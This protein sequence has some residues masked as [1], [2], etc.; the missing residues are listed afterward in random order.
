MLLLFLIPGLLPAQELKKL[1]LQQ[2]YEL[3]QK[4]Y[5]AIRQKDLIRQTSAIN[6][7]NLQKGF[8]P[9]VTISGQAT[10][11]SDVTKIDVSLPGFSFDPPG[12][13]QY[14]LVADV[15]QLIYDGGVTKEQKVVQRLTASV[16]DQ[17]VEVELY[18]LKERINQ[19]Y[20]SIL[21]LDEQLKQV[22]LVKA[23]I[24]IGIKRVDAQVQNGV[25]FKSNLNMLKA[26]L[27]KTEQRAI[28]VKTSKK[29][30]IDALAI[31]IG[32]PLNENIELEKPAMVTTVNEEITRPELKLYSDQAKLIDQQNKLISAKNLPK[33][34]LFVQ[35]GYGKPGLN[36]LKNG[37]DPYYIGGVRFNW[38]LGGLYTKKKEKELT[39]VNKK[40]VDIQKETFV[41][42]TNT[43]LKQQQSEIDKLTRL[44]LSDNEI[45][46]L[47][48]TVTDAAKTQLEN[49]VITAIDYL[50]QVNAE[51]QARQTLIMH[52]LQLLQAQINYQTISGKQ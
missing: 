43:Q 40:I 2:A 3:S 8:L 4:N 38:S 15:S 46:D 36:F 50:N 24:Q 35:G 12:K 21:Y 49:G 16:E 18:K 37:F 51:D 10:Y 33:A 32:Q 9:Q 45:I 44:V 13:D 28:E 52:Q 11:Q 7:E 34:S 19:I 41:L 42:N 22:E 30:L 6:I 1:N 25:A 31:F 14:K 5:P 26:E 47:R 29:G 20:L 23:D 48:K 39:E 27:L 17:K